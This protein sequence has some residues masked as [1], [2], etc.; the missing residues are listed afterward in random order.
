[1]FKM[2][3]LKRLGNAILRLVFANTVNASFNYTFFQ[4]LYK[5]YVAFNSS[6]IPDFDDAMTQF[7]LNFFKFRKLNIALVFANDSTF[8]D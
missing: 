1:M 8:S 6:K 5:H 4:L 3:I 7:Y 2:N